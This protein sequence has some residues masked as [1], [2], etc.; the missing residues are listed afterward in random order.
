MGDNSIYIAFVWHMHQ[1]YYKDL[2]TGKYEMP[3]VRL[4]GAKDYHFMVEL[5]DKY[6]KIKQTFNLVPSLISQLND[7]VF[8]NA[9]D[10][11]FELTEKKAAELDPDDKAFILWN[12]FMANWDNMIKPYPRYFELLEKRGYYVSQ[13]ELPEIALRFTVQD[14][15]DLQVWFNLS[16]F[17]PLTVEKDPLLLAL[18]AKGRKFTETDKQVVMTK[19]KELLAR[20]IPK[21]KEVMERGQIEITTTPFYH[22]ILPLVYDTSIAKVSLPRLNMNFTFSA[23]EDAEEQVKRAVILHEKTF[24]VKPKGLW[25]AEGSVSE[26]IIP[27]LSGY[28]IKWISSDEEILMHS[29]KIFSGKNNYL[30]KPYIVKKNG[31][32]VNII[33]R[34]KELADAIGFLY[35]KWDAE[36]AVNDFIE[37]I[38]GIANSTDIQNPLISI[39]LDGENAWEYYKNNAL[40]F[41]NVLY[42]RLSKDSRIQ[43]TTVSDYLE[44]FPPKETLPYLY[45][46]SWINHD[47]YIWI[48]HEE[49]IK[50]WDY[51]NRVR[52]D[53][54]NWKDEIKARDPDAYEKIMEE[55]LISEGSDWNWWYGDDHSSVQDEEFDKL[56]RKHL[57]NI[58]EFAGKK[59]PPYLLTPVINDAKA[60]IPQI[61]VTGFIKPVIDG[62]ITNFYEWSAAGVFEVIKAGAAIHRAE[63]ITKAL[64]FG[65]DNAQLYLRMDFNVPL[66]VEK[67][68][69]YNFEIIIF[70][71]YFYKISFDLNNLGGDILHDFASQTEDKKNWI[72]KETAGIRIK[73]IKVVEIAIPF[74]KLCLLEGESVAFS[75]VVKKGANEIEKWPVMGNIVVN[76]PTKDFE[77]INWQ[78]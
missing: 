41:F 9:T 6:P 24:G 40:D 2:A 21:Y 48:G 66:S 51:L 64:Y 1:P 45:P 8:N 67:Y 76:V 55:M 37:K 53:L 75:F 43:T 70:C 62:K 58:Y 23:P 52:Q 57:S 25:P 61:A 71:R 77:S 36:A 63:T 5:L 49:D 32:E 7:Y 73:A 17:D 10:T 30:Y 13:K 12:C 38:Y 26:D 42:D 20:I 54:N 18:K 29:L 78:V 14:Y 22:P 28:G 27:L 65:F 31:S 15:L 72:N 33:F 68:K 69:D 35:S 11:V 59:V 47:F 19:Q 3:W 39:I 46:G 34:N 74:E 50:A 16:W 56:F 4:H 60:V 44:K